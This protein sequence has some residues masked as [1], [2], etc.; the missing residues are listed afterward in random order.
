MK[1]IYTFL[2]F[3]LFLLASCVNSYKEVDLLLDY[4]PN[5]NHIGFYVAQDKGFYNDVGLDVNIVPS[6]STTVEQAVSENVVDFGVSYE[7]TTTMSRDKGLD[8]VSIYA[9]LKENTSGFISNANKNIKGPNDLGNKTYCGYLNGVNESIISSVASAAGV[10]PTSIEFINVSTNYLNTQTNECDFFWEYA[11][12]GK[13]EA[14]LEN[15]DYNYIPLIDYGVNFY[16]PVIITSQSYIDSNYDDVNAFVEA[17]IKGY[18]YSATHKEE[19][20]DIFLKYNKGYD[21]ELIEKSLDYLSGY[22]A[23]EKYGYQNGDVWSEFTSFL[24]END[25]IKD[26]ELK[27]VYTNE[28]VNNYYQS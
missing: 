2:I 9:I 26:Q 5:T 16:S 15:I 10:D 18:E 6:V 21:K 4:V 25:Q 27:G 20:T 24:F 17:T 1:K 3:T 8:V 23:D 22:F 7:E 11:G 13:I 28:F 12:W 14:D 19:A